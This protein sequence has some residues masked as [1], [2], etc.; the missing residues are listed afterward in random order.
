[1]VADLQL[2][3]VALGLDAY[4]DWRARGRMDEGVTHKVSDHLAE[5]TRVSGH[6]NCSVVMKG[7]LTVG[8][9]GTA[10]VDGIGDEA[11]EVHRRHRYLRELVEPR[12]GEEVLHEL[13]HAGGFLLDP[14]CR[15]RGL[16]GFPDYP[17]PE[18]LGIAADRRERR[19]QLMRCIRQ[20]AP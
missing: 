7:H 4:L 10:V 3:A 1:V 2:R 12:K 14:S 16:V 11:C 13:P 20:E 8:G 19:P 15:L 18:E 9:G 17:E 6:R 5:L